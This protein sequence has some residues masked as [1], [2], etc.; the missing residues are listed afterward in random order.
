MAARALGGWLVLAA[1]VL[2]L[3]G[4]VKGHL[5]TNI[6]ADKGLANNG[7]GLGGHLGLG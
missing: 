5:A 6:G 2:K 3:L 1:M 4:C 7:G